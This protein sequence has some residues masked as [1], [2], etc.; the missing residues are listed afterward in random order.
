MNEQIEKTKAEK[1]G[2]AMWTF[3]KVVLFLGAYLGLH[4][5]LIHLMVTGVA[6]GVIGVGYA[7][8]MSVFITAMIHFYGFLIQV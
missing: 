1:A 7:I 4:G 3:T 2:K 8:V 5:L 6:A